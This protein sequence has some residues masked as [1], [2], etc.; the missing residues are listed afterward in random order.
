[1]KKNILKNRK[2]QFYEFSKI[3]DNHWF[4]LL[5]YLISVYHLWK[6]SILMYGDVTNNLINKDFYSRK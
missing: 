1:M 5:H 2:E 4:I 3:E 6:L